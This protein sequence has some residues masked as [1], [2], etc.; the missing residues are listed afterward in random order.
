M[1]LDANRYGKVDQVQRDLEEASWLRVLRAFDADDILAGWERYQANGPRAEDGTLRRPSAHCI[2][3]R[4]ASIKD[5]RLRRERSSLP[6]PP[7]PAEPERIPCSPEAAA[8]ILAEAGITPELSN[9]LKRFPRST[10]R[11][12]AFEKADQPPEKRMAY[13]TD[14]ER[15]RAARAA[16]RERGAL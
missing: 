3:S 9:V 8:R 1:I 12:E 14:P 13:E 15:L 6:P 5:A 4:S 7:R 2:A 11:E 16:A 10:T